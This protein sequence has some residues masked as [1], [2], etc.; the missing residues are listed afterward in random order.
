MPKEKKTLPDLSKYYFKTNFVSMDHP[1]HLMSP[2]KRRSPTGGTEGVP[3][4]MELGAALGMD[5]KDGM[6]EL[7]FEQHEGRFKMYR[8]L[9]TVFSWLGY[10]IFAGLAFGVLAYVAFVLLDLDV[11]DSDFF[12]T[13]LL[14]LLA[15]ISFKS[16]SRVVSV[17]FDRYY[18]DT[19]SFVSCLYLLVNLTKRNSLL[20][21]RDRKQLLARIRGVRRYTNL[22]PYQYGVTD[23]ASHSWAG[24]QFRR[25]EEFVEEK[26]NQIVA[27]SA[28]SQV[29]MFVELRAFLEILL[30]GNYGEF[31]YPA[32]TRAETSTAPLKPGTIAGG[33]LKFLGIITP[34]FLVLS[35]FLFPEQLSFLGIEKNVIGYIS[36][37]WLLLA[38]DANLKLGIVQ[39]LSNLSRTIK[40]LS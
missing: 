36:L 6:V 22:L 14:V 12:L 24:G 9:H 17:L 20:R 38:I 30:S 23:P 13:M 15:Y 10:F 7:A 29:E 21:A 32:S 5:L 2:V 19:L 33:I 16:A 1:M 34:V 11:T 4:L 40:D 35:V 28:N 37:A 27:P 18:A 39:G 25:M 3:T 26:E 8:F 31:T